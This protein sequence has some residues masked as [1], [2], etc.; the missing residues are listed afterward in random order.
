MVLLLLRKRR[1]SFGGLWPCIYRGGDEFES[2]AILFW[3]DGGEAMLEV[4]DG[5]TCGEVDDCFVW[6]WL[7]Q[8]EDF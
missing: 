1:S 6:A 2:L 4:V 7:K 5:G 3:E 8:R